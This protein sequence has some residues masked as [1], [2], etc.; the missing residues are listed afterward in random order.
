MNCEMC[1]ADNA[2]YKAIIEGTEL[3][4][5]SACSKHGKV[6]RKPQMIIRQKEFARF[7]KE[8]K[9]EIIEKVIS[10]YGAKIRKARAKK[11][12]TQEEFAK[13]LNI[14]E[15]LLTKIEN[16]SFKPSLPLAQKLEKLLKIRLIEEV[17][18]EKLKIK[19]SE[20][21]SV[22]VGDLIDFE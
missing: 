18:E 19:K 2:E 3:S 7:K 20:T 21:E 13:K 5:C 1:G 4:V 17:E 14:K 16:S 12:M 8:E 6:L 10:D 15:S 9:P 11:K 22:T